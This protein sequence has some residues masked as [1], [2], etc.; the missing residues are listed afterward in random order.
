MP[1]DND[2]SVIST[3]GRNRK[4]IVS[5]KAAHLDESISVGPPRDRQDDPVDERFRMMSLAEPCAPSSL[6][7]APGAEMQRNCT[8]CP[9]IPPDYC[10][11]L[12]SSTSARF[13][14][15]HA[16]IR[17]KRTRPTLV[18]LG[19]LVKLA[20]LEKKTLLCRLQTRLRTWK[21]LAEWWNHLEDCQHSPSRGSFPRPFRPCN[22][23]SSIPYLFMP[24]ELRHKT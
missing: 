19:N 13:A 15:C 9:R 21:M 24:G 17:A 8:S 20:G 11:H 3:A 4:D 10:C 7:G 18:G 12:G 1:R 22:C 14:A 6:T 2:D 5:P 23:R 16:M